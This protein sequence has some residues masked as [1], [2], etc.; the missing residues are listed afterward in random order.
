MLVFLGASAT[1]P[2]CLALGSKLRCGAG[3]WDHG[4]NCSEGF[5]CAQVVVD[6]FSTGLPLFS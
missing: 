3:V 1:G 5:V 2:L 6:S 4:T